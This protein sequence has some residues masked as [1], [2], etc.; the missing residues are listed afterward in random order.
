[1][2]EA[3]QISQLVALFL[4]A[5]YG[6][7]H[8]T[9]AGGA[10]P[11]HGGRGA[12]PPDETGRA[13]PKARVNAYFSH[14]LSHFLV[15]FHCFFACFVIQYLS[16]I[17]WREV[18]K[19]TQPLRRDEDTVLA[20]AAAIDRDT[21][22]FERRMKYQAEKDR[23]HNLIYTDEALTE[24]QGNADTAQHAIDRAMYWDVLRD[25]DRETALLLVLRHCMGY[26]ATEI[27]AGLGISYGRVKYICD[28]AKQHSTYARRA[29]GI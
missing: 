1:M 17:Y 23:A 20:A 26:S 27:S 14:V 22:A 10:M 19:V 8:L 2:C 18:R 25:L 16:M 6:Q 7:P 15:V 24:L 13:P 21:A 5:L 9:R 29:A 3:R 4:I 28:K 12:T 11:G